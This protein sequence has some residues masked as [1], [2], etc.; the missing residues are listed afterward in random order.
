MEVFHLLDV[1]ADIGIECKGTTLKELFNAALSGLYYIIFDALIDYKKLTFTKAEYLHINKKSRA[2]A[3]LMVLE[4]AIYLVY[5]KKLVFRVDE[6]D[7]TL[8]V[9]KYNAYNCHLKIEKEV[10]AVTLHNYSVEWQEN[11][12]LWQARIIFDI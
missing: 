7:E 12:N 1:T 2:D 6:I 4:E 11:S 8:G 9:I 5:Q 10:K 3:L